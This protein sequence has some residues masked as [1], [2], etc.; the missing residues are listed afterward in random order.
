MDK[1]INKKPKYKFVLSVL[2]YVVAGLLFVLAFIGIVTKLSG[3]SL[4]LFGYRL[5][6]VL[7]DSMS[8]KNPDYEEFLKGHDN[9]IQA[10]DVAITKV[11]VHESEIDVYDIV[12]FN[13]PMLHVT[14]MHRI[15]GKTFKDQDEITALKS[16][17]G[18]INGIKGIT[19]DSVKGGI[20]SNVIC[21]KQVTLATYSTIYDERDHFGFSH[22]AGFYDATVSR[23][24]KD[25]G[26]YTYYSVSI[27][28]EY[29]RTLTIAHKCEYDYSS[30]V[31]S[32]CRITT[33]NGVCDLNE[34]TLSVKDDGLF[35][36]YN[37]RYYYEIRGDAANTSDG[38]SF[39]INDIIGKVVG[40]IP[41]IGY[42]IRYLSSV[43]GMVSLI[44]V[45][46]LIIAFDIISSRMAKKEEQQLEA[47]AN[48]QVV[49]EKEVEDEQEKSND[50]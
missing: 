44:G 46:V 4:P 13:N 43:W 10:K 37:Q 9:Q 40:T 42:F 7:T 29:P 50:N 2:I 17:I 49:E 22:Q 47:T 5:D 31:I 21:V 33:E 48:E 16:H 35:G 15:V 38:K 24:E 18:E 25:G 26:Y 12:L 1:T 34:S 23:E 14:D 41:K 45:G 20:V 27:D 6:V 8:Y 19:F 32:S 30:E 3:N 11:G 28:Y 39:T 36:A